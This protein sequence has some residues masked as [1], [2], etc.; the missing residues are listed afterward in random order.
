MTLK[1]NYAQGDIT[2]SIRDLPDLLAPQVVRFRPAHLEI[3]ELLVTHL[4]FSNLPRRVVPGWLDGLLGANLPFEVDFFLE[5]QDNRTAIGRLQKRRK[6][7]YSSTITDKEKGR[8]TSPEVEVA[9]EDINLLT[10]KLESGVDKL[11]NLDVL[12]TVWADTPTELKERIQLVTQAITRCGADSRKL[13]LE[14]RKGFASL[15]PD[16]RNYVH[17]PKKI[18]ATTAAFTF[19][20]ASTD[21]AMEHGILLGVNMLEY[22]PV[23]VNLLERRYLSNP[24]VCVVGKSGCGKSFFVKMLLMRLLL[25][26]YRI[27]VIDPENEYDRLAKEAGGKIIYLSPNHA[28]AFNPFELPATADG[29]IWTGKLSGQEAS[30]PLTEKAGMLVALLT[31]M[32]TG[33]SRGDTSGGEGLD[34]QARDLLDKAIFETYRRCRITRDAVLSGKLSATTLAANTNAYADLLLSAG[35]NREA[36]RSFQKARIPTLADLQDTLIDLGDS[37][38]LAGGL[39]RY[40]SGSFASFLSNR[41]TGLSHEDYLTVFK[42]REVSKELQPIVMFLAMD[43]C[44][45]L[46]VRYR[47]PM[48]FALDELWTLISS[49]LGGSLVEQFARRSRKLG[50][51]L[52]V[53]TQQV[54]DLLASPQGRAIFGNCD[55]KWIGQQEGQHR[56]ILKEALGLT[57]AQID[58]VVRTAVAG[59]ALF[60]CGSRAVPLS[61]VHSELEYRLAQTNPL[62]SSAG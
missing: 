25:T 8:L 20:F 59:Q 36:S 14:Q 44:W 62:E 60:K 29:Q 35:R 27:F 5:P 17:K 53:A 40:I 9:L 61:V 38:G 48:L 54:E 55:T 46:A 50:L 28:F 52:V 51:S 24:N 18:D 57:E 22:S 13:H 37:Y 30:D 2:E 41:P 16:G 7:L 26:G 12:V 21:L 39:E 3:N 31:M 56:Q 19:P 47:Q 11:L 10:E 33:S 1:T 4:Y 58:F 15:L 34:R 6:D 49:I 45:S 42:I 32:I 23:I 43:W